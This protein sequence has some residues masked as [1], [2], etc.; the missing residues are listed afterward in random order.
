MEHR[1]G[2]VDA[3]WSIQ[4]PAALVNPRGCPITLMDSSFLLRFLPRATLHWALP[5][6]LP[7]FGPL[8]LQRQH[9][10]PFWAP[11]LG[12][13]L[14]GTPWGSGSDLEKGDGA[15]WHQATGGWSRG[16]TVGGSAFISVP[17]CREVC[18]GQRC[19]VLGES[20]V[21]QRLPS[22]PLGLCQGKARAGCHVGCL[23]S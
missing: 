1:R 16:D 13:G 17:F 12:L 15:G 11:L 6:C 9:H 4:V 5:F 2:S 18:C 8:T 21:R 14:Q 19:I 20:D 23:W 10:F 3:A 22:Q 7:L